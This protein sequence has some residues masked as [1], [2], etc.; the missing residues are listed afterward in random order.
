MSYNSIVYT[1]QEYIFKSLTG[2]LII[3]TIFER[4]KSMLSQRS[5][6]HIPGTF[7]HLTR[8]NKIVILVD[9]LFVVRKT[10]GMKEFPETLPNWKAYAEIKQLVTQITNERQASIVYE[11]TWT[12]ELDLTGA[13][14]Q[15][16]NVLNMWP[17]QKKRIALLKSLVLRLETM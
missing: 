2:C 8:T 9:L 13:D 5:W 12:C 7:V 17:I 14:F 11:I 15:E 16:A 1:E 6:F 4:V 10:V 3:L